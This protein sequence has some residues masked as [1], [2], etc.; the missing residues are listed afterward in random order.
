[1]PSCSCHDGNLS[2]P[3]NLPRAHVAGVRSAPLALPGV[4][5][6]F[7]SHALRRIAAVLLLAAISFVSQQAAAATLSISG[8]PPTTAVTY[9]PYSFVP[10]VTR[11]SSTRALYFRIRNKPA[12]MRFDSATGAISGSPRRAQYN[13]NI[14]ISVSDGRSRAYLPA[15]SVRVSSGTGTANQAPTISGS[16]AATVQATQAYSFAPSA[17]DPEGKTLM[18]SIENKPAWASFSTVSGALSGTPDGTQVGTYSNISIRVTDGALTASLPSFAI[19]VTAAPAP[20]NRAPVISGTPLTSVVAGSAY[21]FQPTASDADGNTLSFSI[22]AKPAWATFSGTTGRLTGSPTATDV[23][24][25]ANIVVSVSDGKVSASLAPF[26]ITVG[27]PKLG[28][29]S[30][31]WVAP[32]QNSNGTALTDLA[33]YRI[34]YGNSPTALTQTVQVG[35]PSVTTYLV[36]NLPTGTWYFSVKSYNSAGVESQQSAPVSSVVN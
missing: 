6:M 1:M 13:T 23:G 35:N 4:S 16:P 20:A 29:V 32:T 14:S 27:P 3:G 24:S 28:S 22:S 36:E 30:L 34:V 26:S 25:Y 11:A 17:S 18:F 33:G 8:T 5:S 9:Q 31:D 10:T 7:I 2:F 19:S 12:W 21:N 15:F